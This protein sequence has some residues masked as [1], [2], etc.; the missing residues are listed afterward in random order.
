MRISVDENSRV[1]L[2]CTFP[3]LDHNV[4][5]V[6]RLQICII[7]SVLAMALHTVECE[8][9]LTGKRLATKLVTQLGHEQ[10]KMREQASVKLIEL[11]IVG[12]DALLAGRSS[13]NREIRYRS[14]KLFALVFEADLENRLEAFERSDDPTQG[15]GLPGWQR[16][17]KEVGTD[18]TS[19]ALFMSMQEQERKLLQ[20]VVDDNRIRG[21]FARYCEHLEKQYLLG[22]RPSNTATIATLLF[23]GNDTRVHVTDSIRRM[24]SVSCRDPDFIATIREGKNRT[25]LAKLV[26]N[27]IV[28][29]AE[30]EV[31]NVLYLGLITNVDRCLPY[32]RQVLKTPQNNVERQLCALL[33]LAKFGKANDIPLLEELLDNKTVYAQSQLAARVIET[34]IRD[35]ALAALVQIT[36]Q[37]PL[38][39]GFDRMQTH[40]NEVFY[41]RSLGFTSE[42]KRTAAIAAWHKYRRAPQNKE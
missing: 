13:P 22:R 39:Y 25:P 37:K 3:Q 5:K 42:E 7:G 1:G 14:N 34:Q 19:R 41:P 8:G 27:W 20:A 11:G 9:E 23:V 31:W 26:S 18:A 38:D 12:S 33:C 21:E 30:H 15:Y 32:A 35:V 40:R 16:F 36:G 10:F 2:E 6:S 28:R 29:D 4:I 24:I 17:R